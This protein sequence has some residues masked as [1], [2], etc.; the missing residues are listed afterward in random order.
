M[1]IPAV[2]I[3]HGA[4]AA[5]IEAAL[6]DDELNQF[7]FEKVARWCY[8]PAI[9]LWQELLDRGLALGLG[10]PLSTLPQF[11]AWDPELLVRTEGPVGS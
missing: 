11:E 4:D 3:P 9:K 7:Y 10:I 5:T 8:R 6:F 1:R 2:P